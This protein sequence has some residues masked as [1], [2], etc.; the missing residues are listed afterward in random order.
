M[1]SVS[2]IVILFVTVLAVVSASFYDGDVTCSEENHACARMEIECDGCTVI[3]SGRANAC[4]G[5]KI[6]GAAK[7]IC[8]GEQNACMTAQIFKVGHIRC[9]GKHNACVRATLSAA[10]VECA[11]EIN[12]CR[13]SVKS[14]VERRPVKHKKEDHQMENRHS[15]HASNRLDSILSGSGMSSSIPYPSPILP[16]TY[17]ESVTRSGVS[18]DAKKRKRRNFEAMNNDLDGIT[19]AIDNVRTGNKLISDH[20]I[21]QDSA[22]V[23]L[24]SQSV[25]HKRNIKYLQSTICQL[26]QNITSSEA[27]NNEYER[28]ISLQR[29]NIDNLT[30][31]ISFMS[32]KIEGLVNKVALLEQNF[33]ESKENN[34]NLQ[35]KNGQL[36][37]KVEALEIEAQKLE[38]KEELLIWAEK[39]L[40][41]AQK[42]DSELRE[43]FADIQAVLQKQRSE[44]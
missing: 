11:Q 28:I 34:T 17:P 10:V 23:N 16:I 5:T 41:R 25:N 30:A 33:E 40:L 36:L 32:S 2:V 19:T 15:L 42:K 22:N 8:S 29:A 3:C 39:E 1:S 21:S 31:K 7:V 6:H 12:T 24:E 20:I 27:E 4:S 9:L 26:E 35:S 14:T 13:D 38:L 18:A 44:L 43:T 37:E